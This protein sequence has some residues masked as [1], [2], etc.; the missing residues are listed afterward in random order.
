MSAGSG[1]AYKS[2][3]LSRDG[4]KMMV[5]PTL[6]ISLLSSDS[7][8][9]IGKKFS[10]QNKSRSHIQFRES[11]QDWNFYQ[12]TKSK[13]PFFDVELSETPVES[14]NN[15]RER[16]PNSV[17]NYKCRLYE[18]NYMNSAEKSSRYQTPQSL[19]NTKIDYEKNP[20]S[21]GVFKLT[22]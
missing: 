13:L 5:A 2:S 1:A 9:S 11:K 3:I 8:N 7:L 15:L 4:D 6:T 18:A 21:P 10:L 12:C 14:D 16:D 20:R 19:Q 17:F 22:T